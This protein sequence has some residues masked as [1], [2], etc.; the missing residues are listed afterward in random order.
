M[1]KISKKIIIFEIIIL[2]ILVAVWGIGHLGS[3][4]PTNKASNEL[5]QESNMVQA[6]LDMPILNITFFDVGKGDCILIETKNKAVMIDTGYDKNGKDIVDWLNDRGIESLSYL[7]LTHPDKDHIG[8]ASYI[9]NHM[10]VAQVI[11][12]DCE[13][14]SNHYKE[15]HEASANRGV[16][17]LTLKESKEITLEK[18]TL[19]IYPPISG[20]FEGENNYSLVTK[21]VYGDTNFLFT[22]DAQEDRLTELFTQI[23][24]LKSTLLKVPHHGTWMANSEQFFKAVSPKYSIITSNKEKKYKDVTEI[25]QTIGSEVF[26]TNDGDITVQSNGKQIGIRQ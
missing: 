6:S 5:N 16:P 25:L 3:K 20:D 7:I 23:P 12:T 26:T 11:D 14:D 13:V 8:G 10:T 4:N 9:I 18:A 19:T 15:Y 1:K 21:L 2:T 22:G 24:D 17:I